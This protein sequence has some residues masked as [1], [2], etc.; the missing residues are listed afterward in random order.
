MS[1]K[2]GNM[3]FDIKGRTQIDAVQ[4]ERAENAILI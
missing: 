4:E 3:A 1:A 2:L